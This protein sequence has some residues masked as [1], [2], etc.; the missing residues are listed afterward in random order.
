MVHFRL[1]E[2]NSL[3]NGSFG[4]LIEKIGFYREH[5]KFYNIPFI[6]NKHYL[7]KFGRVNQQVGHY[8]QKKRLE[9][10]N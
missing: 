5:Y 10:V 6:Q 2:F 3:K 7:N 9:D 1:D 4:L 8:E